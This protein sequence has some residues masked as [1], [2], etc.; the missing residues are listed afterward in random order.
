MCRSDAFLIH[1]NEDGQ[2]RW[3]TELNIE[4]VGVP[5]SGP[6]EVPGGFLFQGY[7]AGLIFF[8][9]I[10]FDG[11]LDWRT[12]Q[13]P[14]T[15]HGADMILMDNND[16]YVSFSTPIDGENKLAHCQLSPNGE[17]LNQRFLEI[18][19]KMDVAMSSAM[20]NDRKVSLVANR[21]L[22]DGYN[23]GLGDFVIQYSLDTLSTSCF[24]WQN[25]DGNRAHVQDM[26]FIRYDTTI[27]DSR[28]V[29]EN[30]TRAYALPVET[31][32]WSRC[33]STVVTNDQ[34]VDTMLACDIDWEIT[35]PDG[36]FYWIDLDS[37]SPRSITRSG[38]YYAKN[39]SCGEPVQLT[40]ILTRP[41]CECKVYLPTAITPNGDGLNDVLQLYSDCPMVSFEIR[42]YDRWGK[43]VYFNASGSVGWDGT[44]Q[45][46]YLAN[47]LYVAHSEF[48][49][50]DETGEER[51]GS[52]YQE[53]H[54]VR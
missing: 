34:T 16:I 49:V 19:Q 39:R 42:V 11:S 37:E 12:D 10:K 41:D 3:A 47:G 53:L 8:Y 5:I 25:F 4:D 36:G 17:I 31:E 9:K 22:H 45:G 48:R 50:L 29:L 35:L 27:L 2:L 18:D 6:L 33:D 38:T 20:V 15:D 14:S 46:E 54:L 26:V 7:R 30:N 28:M 51:T 40:Y 24:S 44:Q 32:Y 43:Q 21:S 13:I 1:L 23:G 52:L